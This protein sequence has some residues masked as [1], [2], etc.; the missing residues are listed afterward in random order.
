[1]ILCLGL[2]P[3]LQRTMICKSIQFN[4]V[5][6][7][8]QVILSA[9]GKA[10]NTA[11]ALAALG[12]DSRASGFNGGVSG[13]LIKG[14]LAEYKVN[15]ALTAMKADTRICSTLIDE[16]TGMVTELVEEASQPSEKEITN[17]IQRNTEL[18][19]ESQ[20]LVICGT[21]P[22]WAPDDFYRHFTVTA[23][24]LDVP[25]IIDSHK[26]ALLSVLQDNPL[27]AK[28]N[29][30]ELETT[31]GESIKSEPQLIDLMGRLISGGAKSVFLTQGKDASYLLE[32]GT[33][34]KDLPPEIAKHL[35]PIGS[36]DCTTAG[37]AYA[38]GN[39]DTLQESVKFGLACG[40]ANVESLIPADISRERVLQLLRS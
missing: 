34:S 6:R 19:K 1:M 7:V 10:V 24:R 31:F 11:R 40:S 37:I 28:L 13:E 21:L 23:A 18:I 32:G 29:F 2:T 25:V 15:S 27:V 8:Q 33:L 20:M 9:A 5:N 14:F 39:G 30:K 16:S 36:G 38:L 3:A 12:A 26:G 17:F 35:S 22:P 4:E